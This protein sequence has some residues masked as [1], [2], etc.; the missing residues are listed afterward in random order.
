MDVKSHN[1]ERMVELHNIISEGVHKVGNIEE[2]VHS[3]FLAVMNPEDKHSVSGFK[4]FSDRIEYINLL[5]VLDFKTEVEIYRNI[6]GEHI[7]SYFLPRVLNNFARV[8]ISTRLSFKSEALI[9]WIGNSDKYDRYCD[10]NLQLLKMEI[11]TGNIPT[12]LSESATKRFNAKRRRNIIAESEKEGL[13]GFSGRD[14]IKIF[15][16]FFSTYAEEDKYI[17]MSDLHAFFNKLRKSAGSS[18]FEEFLDSLLNMYNYTILEEVKE[19]LYYYNEE[20]ISRDIQN[21]LFALNFEISSKEV[22]TFTGDTL[23]ITSDFLEEIENRL[24]DT[25]DAGRRATFRK[26]IQKEYT[27][28][29]LTQEMILEDKPITKTDLYES[30]CEKYAYNLKEKVLEPFLDNKNFR[31][32]IKDFDKKNFKTYDKRIKKDITFLIKNLCN[33]Y[34]Y[35]KKGAQEICMYVID[36]DLAKKFSEEK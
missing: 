14:S 17:N 34:G 8:I 31:R 28:K 27:S 4:S 21:Y 5:Y 11:Y 26:D 20:Q 13:K 6:F 1:I 29:T 18:I 3:L 12:W 32:G 35:T 36:N 23:E 16:D 19:S 33:N 7:D 10:K 22:C 30:L 15:N 24:L 9:E 2:N 25:K